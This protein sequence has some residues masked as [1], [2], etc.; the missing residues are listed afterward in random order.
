MLIITPPLFL[1]ALVWSPFDR[2]GNL[3][4]RLTCFWCKVVLKGCFFNV[5]VEG[6]DRA[7]PREP[8]IFMPNHSSIFDHLV[9]LAY[10][11]VSFRYVG[12]EE[13]FSLPFFGWVCTHARYIPLNRSRPREGILTLEKTAEIINDGVSIVIYPKGTRSKDGQ[14]HKFKRGG[15]LLAVKTGHRII[16]VSI[17][18]AQ[19]IMPTKSLKVSPG[20]IKVVLG[21][22]ISTNGEGRAEQAEL[23]EEVHKVIEANYDPEYGARE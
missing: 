1:I 20:S 14:I 4:H 17:S 19:R 16:P 15:F 23:M 12:K 21:Q 2:K 10:L 8:Y 7:D 18:G 11:P 13:I 22:P 3:V 9:L 5:C 6:K